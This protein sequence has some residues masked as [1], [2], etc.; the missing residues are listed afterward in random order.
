MG[1][2]AGNVY[3]PSKRFNHHVYWDTDTSGTDQG[4]GRGNKNGITGLNS[5]ELQSGLP[6][7]FDPT[8]WAQNPKINNGFPYLIANP[9]PK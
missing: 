3:P 1:G 7:G 6:N 5:A 4:T 8:I 2:Y 9:P